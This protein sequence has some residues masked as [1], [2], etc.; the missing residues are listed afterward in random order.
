MRECIRYYNAQKTGKHWYVKK[1]PQSQWNA[2]FLFVVREA[3][4]EP[5]RPEW[6]L[7]PESSESA[8]S[9]TRAF[10]VFQLLGYITTDIPACQADETEKV[11]K[12][13]PAF[14]D[15]CNRM[16]CAGLYIQT[17]IRRLCIYQNIGILSIPWPHL[18]G[19]SLFPICLRQ[20]WHPVRVYRVQRGLTKAV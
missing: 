5:A 9:T 19:T 8:N 16:C 20:H 4:L 18:D 2:G 3:G 10:T 14:F 15:V 7:E 13:L 17:V 11:A 1:N 6:T 12:N